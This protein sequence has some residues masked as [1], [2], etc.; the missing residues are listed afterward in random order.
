MFFF[1]NSLP[2]VFLHRKKTS[3]NTK[4]F[5]ENQ[6]MLLMDMFTI[7]IVVMVSHAYT[8]IKIYQI[9]YFRFVKLTICL[10]YFN[11]EKLEKILWLLWLEEWS[12]H[13]VKKENIFEGGLSV[14]LW[15]YYIWQV[16]RHLNELSSECLNT[17]LEV[18]EELLAGNSCESQ[19]PIHS[20]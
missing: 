10:L 15:I 2:W 12:C 8:C 18:E 13:Q 16:F 20:I 17:N 1:I 3:S 6:N 4:G 9:I 5:K 14:W 7:L 19:W 11:K